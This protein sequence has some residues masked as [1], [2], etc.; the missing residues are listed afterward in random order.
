MTDIRQRLFDMGEEKYGDFSARLSPT[1]ARER[2]IGVRSP[3]LRSLAKELEGTREAELFMESLP[4]RY[5]EEDSLH[6]LLIERIK[7]YDRCV[8][9]LD[10]FLPYVDNWA[11]CDTM[12]PKTFKKHRAEL[13]EDIRRWTGDGRCFLYV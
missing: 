3:L 10:S 13:I 9:A 2:I 4:H 5:L 8:A 6:G 11:T 12:S 7:D 1:V